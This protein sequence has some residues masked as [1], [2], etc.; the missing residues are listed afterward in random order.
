MYKRRRRNPIPAYSVA[1]IT[2]EY[3]FHPNTVR[4]WVHRDG[5]RYHRKGRGGKILIREDDLETFLKK[6]YDM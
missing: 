3:G 1:D 2:T 4:A 6:F 5:L